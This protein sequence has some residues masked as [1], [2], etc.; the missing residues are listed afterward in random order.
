MAWPAQQSRTAGFTGALHTQTHART[1]MHTQAQT[2]LS[3]PA[4]DGD[5]SVHSDKSV[6]VRE[7]GERERKSG[8]RKEIGKCLFGTCMVHRSHHIT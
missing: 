1:F 4:A 6:S 8:V 5:K 3:P 2:R 7:R